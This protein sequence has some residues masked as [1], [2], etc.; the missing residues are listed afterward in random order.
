MVGLF[1]RPYGGHEEVGVSCERGTPVIVCFHGA[2]GGLKQIL[3]P[4]RLKYTLD[5]KRSR[6]SGTSS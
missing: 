4:N 1:L 3:I 2:N 6:T 5:P